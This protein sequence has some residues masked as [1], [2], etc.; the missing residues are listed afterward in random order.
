MG[1]MVVM[2]THSTLFGLVAAVTG[3]LAA[4][5]ALSGAANSAV[6]LHGAT[7]F[8]DGLHDVAD[9]AKGIGMAGFCKK[10]TGLRNK[11]ISICHEV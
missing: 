9:L 6:G 8:A 1:M 3:V 11:I 10:P 4:G 2:G 7:Y 5:F